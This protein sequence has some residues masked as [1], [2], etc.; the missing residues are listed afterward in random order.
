MTDDVRKLLA[1][2]A[3]GTL[4]DAERAA[5]FEAALTDEELFAALSDE[6]PLRE[7]L[8]DPACRAE[9]LSR[10][11]PAPAAFRERFAA[12]LRRPVVVGGLATAAVAVIVVSIIPMTQHTPARE[13]VVAE[14]RAPVTPP[15][16]AEAPQAAA[17]AP[18]RSGTK[19]KRADRPPATT[20]PPAAALEPAPSPPVAQETAA[21][22]P[23]ADF[24]R[25]SS[26]ALTTQE[27]RPGAPGTQMR[28]TPGSAE[29]A[30]GAKM[31]SVR[32][33]AE[34]AAATPRFSLLKRSE[35]GEY[36]KVDPA[37]TLFVPGDM[38][39]VRL[40]SGAAG[41]VNVTSPALQPIGGVVPQNGAFETGDIRIGN[42]DM[43]L[44]VTFTAVPRVVS[45][46]VRSELAEAPQPPASEF[47]LRVKK[48]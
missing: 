27:A 36:V 32:R 5:L 34:P 29:V 15:A 8:S 40:E 25:R 23:T 43:R 6:D 19:P 21:S 12:W 10:I 37:Q 28:F 38:V 30:K 7:L 2:Y 24:A 17:S 11:E 48:P 20:A 39:R 13:T 45:T 16:P 14:L 33:S 44:I 1:G 22:M 18:V 9:L 35:T 46:L 4:S 42:E 47:V 31:M 3:T 41:V 26:I